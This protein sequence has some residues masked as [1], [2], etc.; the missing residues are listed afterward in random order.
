MVRRGQSIG[1]IGWLRLNDWFELAG[2][3]LGDWVRSPVIQSI[4]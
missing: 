4:G 2:P 1:F 3:G